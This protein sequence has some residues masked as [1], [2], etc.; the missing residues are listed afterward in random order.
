MVCS[1]AILW[2]AG[3]KCCLDVLCLLPQ[4]VS[5]EHG[6]CACIGDAVQGVPLVITMS[7]GADNN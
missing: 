1:E 6:R 3:V 7:F 5:F 4:E 2:V